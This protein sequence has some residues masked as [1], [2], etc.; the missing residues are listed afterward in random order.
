MDYKSFTEISEAADAIGEF[1]ILNKAKLPDHIR[2]R[3][4]GLTRTGSSPVD[5]VGTFCRAVY[6]NR[7]EPGITDEALKLAA[8]GADLFDLKGFHGRL[9]GRA[10]AMS[11][12]L[13]RAAGEKAPAGR[14]FH[15]ES[16]DPVDDAEFKV[17]AEAPETPAPPQR[18]EDQ[19]TPKAPKK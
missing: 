8:G 7:G 19:A 2:D 14:P 5:L 15:A 9:E 1:I 16:A 3:L 17:P 13:L 11:L 10:G 6:A 4:L 18:P 12:T